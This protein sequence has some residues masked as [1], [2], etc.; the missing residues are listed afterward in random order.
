MALP[1]ASKVRRRGAS[2]VPVEPAKKSCEARTVA[3]APSAVSAAAPTALP[4]ALA[5]LSAVLAGSVGSI[6]NS[7]AEVEAAEARAV[8]V[9]VVVVPSWSASLIVTLSP[10]TGW[11][12]GVPSPTV[13]EAGLPPVKSRVRPGPGGVSPG[14]ALCTLARV[15]GAIRP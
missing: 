6:A 14:A 5:R 15:P 12:G 2:P 13:R 4:S 1:P 8:S 7:L 11:V 3:L 9:I 10:T